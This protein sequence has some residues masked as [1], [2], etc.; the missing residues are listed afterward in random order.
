MNIRTYLPILLAVAVMSCEAQNDTI[1][2][3]L[4][5]MS[6]ADAKVVSGSVNMKS[7]V[8]RINSAVSFYDSGGPSGSYSNNENRV[9][10]I[11]PDVT[12]ARVSFRLDVL[13]TEY[14]GGDCTND[15]LEIYDGTSTAAPRLDFWCGTETSFWVP[16]QYVAT[17]SSGALTIRFVSDG[18]VTRSGWS[19]ALSL[20][21]PTTSYVIS[22]PRA[23][24]VAGNSS[25]LV[26]NIIG[27]TQPPADQGVC[28]S[29]TNTLPS[30]TNGASCFTA[31]VNRYGTRVFS[32]PGLG[33]NVTHHM[34]AF[35]TPPGGTTVYT[36]TVSYM[37]LSKALPQE[38]H[39]GAGVD[40]FVALDPLN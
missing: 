7:G 21:T 39:R 5:D 34:R 9:L 13:D 22:S 37:P 14:Y 6:A 38:F 32:Q 11:Y 30:R 33:A 19:G 31:N 27:P 36:S 15:Y 29:T 25:F 26:Y 35:M 18:S 10:T 40:E 1:T 3:S 23:M 17:N 16:F 24:G 2:S 12:G 20:L 28:I 4:F 8:V